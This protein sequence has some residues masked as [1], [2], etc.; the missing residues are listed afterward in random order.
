MEGSTSGSNPSPPASNFK[1]GLNSG[2]FTS[3]QFTSA[4]WAEFKGFLAK[5]YRGDWKNQIFNNAQ[6]Y[7]R[8]V[9]SGDLSILKTFRDGKRLNIMKALAASQSF[10]G[11]MNGISS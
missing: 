3:T 5:D 8:C 9:V 11:V 2:L 6:K 7:S 4:F 10:Q 1:T